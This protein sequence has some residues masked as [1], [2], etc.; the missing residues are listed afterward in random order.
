MCCL[1]V[2]DYGSFVLAL[3]ATPREKGYTGKVA[4]GIWV[5]NASQTHDLV[6]FWGWYG[7]EKLQTLQQSL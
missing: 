3:F 6:W 5:M 4:K 2:V 7:A 1:Q